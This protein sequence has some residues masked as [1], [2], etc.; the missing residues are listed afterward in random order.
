MTDELNGK[1]VFDNWE[2]LVQAS[3]AGKVRLGKN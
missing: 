1:D 2:Q 3:D